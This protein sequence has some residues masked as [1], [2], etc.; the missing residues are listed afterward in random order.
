MQCAMVGLG[1]ERHQSFGCLSQDFGT[2]VL[3]LGQ[4]QS[5]RY[6]LHDRKVMAPLKRLR[7]HDLRLPGRPSP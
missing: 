3:R 4:T 2:Y 1:E 6:S 5:F 7:A